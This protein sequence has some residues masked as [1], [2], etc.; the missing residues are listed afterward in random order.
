[1]NKKELFCRYNQPFKAEVIQSAVN[2]SGSFS[3]IILFI[4][5]STQFAFKP[6]FCPGTY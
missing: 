5:K 4:Q 6:A 1:M 3:E 2:K